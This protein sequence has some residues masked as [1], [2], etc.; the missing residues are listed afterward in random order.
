M[1]LCEKSRSLHRWDGLD[2]M[3]SS[4]LGELVAGLKLARE[5][6]GTL[7][8]ASLSEQAWSVVRLAKLDR[9]FEI[10]PTAEAALASFS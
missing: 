3:D 5:A 9:A 8:L 4:G 2:F 6:G 7:K 1:I 10:H